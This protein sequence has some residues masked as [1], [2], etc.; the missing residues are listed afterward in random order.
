MHYKIQTSFNETEILPLNGFF[1]SF[2]FFS[3]QKVRN[4]K[5]LP[6]DL[7]AINDGLSSLL[8]PSQKAMFSQHMY[9][10]IIVV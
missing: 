2:F 6:V 9:A 3:L 5:L 8:L 7:K 10:S 4:I 1:F